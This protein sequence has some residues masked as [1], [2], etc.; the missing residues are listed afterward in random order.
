M[1]ASIN[2]DETD[3]PVPFD[4]GASLHP[5]EE[6]RLAALRRVAPLVEP[7]DALLASVACQAS[8]RCGAPIGLVSLMDRYEQRFVGCAGF[9][10]GTVDRGTAF[11]AHTILE[12]DPVVV[13]DAR[14]DPRFMNHP[15]VAGGLRVRF[16]AGAPILDH[17]GLPLGTVCV[18]GMRPR[19]ISMKRLLGLQR[20]A[21]M[22]SAVLEARLL[23]AEAYGRRG[24]GM[25]TEAR[26]ALARL[27]VLLMPLVDHKAGNGA[28]GDGPSGS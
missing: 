26:N 15:Q 19:E 28:F 14:T 25:G 12:V 4:L 13:R 2:T 7:G 11:C 20:L 5:L 16:Y 23:V 3:P 9:E 1:T 10:V 17:G 27:D 24:T 6:E 8:A 21:H 22:V 18:F